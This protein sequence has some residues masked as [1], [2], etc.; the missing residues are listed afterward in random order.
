MTAAFDGQELRSFNGADAADL[1]EAYEA[2][3]EA[4]VEWEALPASERAAV[5]SRAAD[6]LERSRDEIAALLRIEAG[7]SALKADIEISS[8]IGITR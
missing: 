2:A 1:D 6:V 7:A 8:A 4:K 3:A 5:I